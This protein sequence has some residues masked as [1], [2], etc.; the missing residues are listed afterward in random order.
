MLVVGQLRDALDNDKF[1][2]DAQPILPLRGL[3]LIHI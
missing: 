1:R 3:S 2:L